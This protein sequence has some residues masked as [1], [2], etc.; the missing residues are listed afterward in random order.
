MKKVALI[1]GIT[2]QDGAYL[3]DELLNNGYVVHGLRRRTSLFN[4]GRIDHLLTDR[5]IGESKI[6]LHYGEMTD[7]TSLYRVVADIEP[8]IIFN[9]AAQSHV[10]VSFESPEYVADV[11]GLGTLRLLEVT[12][13]IDRDIRIYQAST[14][15]LYGGELSVGLSYTEE[16]PFNPKSP[17][18]VA[19]QFAFSMSKV[20]RESYDLFISNGILFNHESPL[21]GEN[22]VTQKIVRAVAKMAR[23]QEHVTLRLGNLDAYRDWGHAADYVNAMRLIAE[24]DQPDDYIVAT[25]E[26]HTVREFLEKVLDFF[27]VEYVRTGT[28]LDEKYLA[29]GGDRILV[30]IDSRYFRPNEVHYLS[31]DP[32]KIKNDLGWAPTHSFDS[33]IT[34]MCG[35][36]E[37]LRPL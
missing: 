24:A 29:K 18:A 17:Y 37:R 36:A 35:N 6:V 21:R 8:S 34:D 3:A 20:Y 14:S 33:L 11:D 2:G 22:F 4:T 15:E 12:R 25:E 9:L 13:Q 19:K 23:G 28:G 32:S 7:F 5:F 26:T 30:E 31:G 27:A 10:A 16:S 1:T